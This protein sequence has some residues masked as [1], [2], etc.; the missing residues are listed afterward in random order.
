VVEHRLCEGDVRVR[1]ALVSLMFLFAG[2]AGAQT[3]RDLLATSNVPSAAFGDVELATPVVGISKSVRDRTVIAFRNGASGGAGLVGPVQVMEYDRVGDAAVR[4][5]LQMK[6]SDGCG[7]G[8]EDIYFVTGF[9]IVGTTT[10]PTAGCLFVLGPDLQLTQMLKALSPVE[11]ATGFVVVAESLGAA[12][13]VQSPRLQMADLQKRTVSE[14]YPPKGD[15]LRVKMAQENEKNVAAKAAENFDEDVH[16][17][18]TDGKGHFAFIVDQ[19]ARN[20]QSTV[21][22]QKVFYLYT[23]GQ[24]SLLYCEEE[25]KNVDVDALDDGMQTNFLRALDRCTPA[26]PVAAGMGAGPS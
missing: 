18:A 17:V 21:A 8:V 13:A 9:T 16:S 20:A 1:D 4:S 22:A 26:L 2:C 12:A 5:Q 14:L 10:S 15:S 24:G 23:L 19:A 6:E 25:L 11:V 7:G 3:L